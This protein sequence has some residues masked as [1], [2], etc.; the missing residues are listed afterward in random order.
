MMSLAIML[1]LVGLCGLM[2]AVWGDWPALGGASVVMMG[3]GCVC[4]CV[5]AGME[6]WRI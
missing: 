6:W 5:A 4:A 2:V 3:L 1:E